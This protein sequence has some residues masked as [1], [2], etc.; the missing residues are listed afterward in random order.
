MS[1]RTGLRPY[2]R[3][4]R[5]TERVSWA[6]TRP[7]Y[8]VEVDHLSSDQLRSFI[9]FLELVYSS[10]VDIVPKRSGEASWLDIK[11]MHISAVGLRVASRLY[12]VPFESLAHQD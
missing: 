6:D 7:V 5:L 8:S 9:E 2:V 3:P 1:A 11:H 12:N 4:S 10:R